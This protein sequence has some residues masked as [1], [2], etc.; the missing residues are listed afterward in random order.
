MRIAQRR[1]PGGA[2]LAKALVQ[3]APTVTLDWDDRQKS[4]LDTQD[5]TGQRLAVV[6]P[7][8][9]VLRGGD[10]LLCDD[11]SLVAVKAAAQA[12]MQVRVRASVRA[13]DPAPYGPPG[14]AVH[15]SPEAATGGASNRMGLVHAAYHLGNRHVPLDIQADH[16]AFEPDPVLADMLHGMGF[17]VQTVQAP[18][19]PQG[20]AYHAHQAAH[21]HASAP[22][23]GHDH[24]GHHGDH[25]YS[26]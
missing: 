15:R 22:G 24:H 25:G 26:H 11:G 14:G 20:G 5:D 7:R 23:H 1:L 17:D 9:T 21:A 2:G 16:V 8:G 13:S 18:F 3:R 6:L 10:V 4:R 12:V 19:E